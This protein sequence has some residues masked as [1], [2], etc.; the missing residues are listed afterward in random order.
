MQVVAL[1]EVCFRVSALVLS[2]CALQTQ[3]FVA[4]FDGQVIVTV[5]AP[6]VPVHLKVPAHAPTC[7]VIVAQAPVPV[8]TGGTPPARIGGKGW[9]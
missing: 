8:S 4:M 7:V 6:V 2:S 5:A 9:V 1:W 3:P